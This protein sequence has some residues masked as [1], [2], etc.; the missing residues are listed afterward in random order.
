MENRVKVNVSGRIFETTRATLNKIP[1]LR[2]MFD[3]CGV[4]SD[5]VITDTIFL[6]RSALVFEHILSYVQ[7]SSHPYPVE[8]KYE[9]N[10][11]GIEYDE[12]RLY[13]ADAKSM[14]LMNEL[15]SKMMARLNAYGDKVDLLFDLT[16]RISSGIR[17]CDTAIEF[18]NF[19]C[20]KTG[21]SESVR[22]CRLTCYAHCNKCVYSDCKTTIAK[23]NYCPDHQP[24]GNRC[25]KKGCWRYR[26]K[27]NTLCFLH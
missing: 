10:F 24:I 5:G 27:D 20:I 17:D 6:D 9:L 22:H 1:Q 14:A 4:D 21:C 2:D 13:H 8:Y 18:R 3:G 25:E 26:L 12:E 7:D 15:N 19:Q 23:S 11:L 16:E